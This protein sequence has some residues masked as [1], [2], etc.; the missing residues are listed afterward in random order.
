MRFSAYPIV[1]VVNILNKDCPICGVS[2]KASS[3]FCSKECKNKSQQNRI[4]YQC[5]SCKK[6]VW[7]TPAQLIKKKTEHI[8]CSQKCVG[9]FKSLKSK[10]QQ[11]IRSCP[12]CNKEFSTTQYY[13]D[14]GKYTFCS[15]I[16]RGISQR[17]IVSV[18]CGWCGT[19]VLKTPSQIEKSV[20]G[21]V[22]CSN[23]CVG[24]YNADKD[25]QNRITKNCVICGSPFPTKPSTEYTHITCS[26]ACQG[27][28]QSET[29]VG[30][31]ANNYQGGGGV[32]NCM[33][34]GEPFD[35]SK[36][37]YENNLSKF[38]KK[39]CK[40]EYWVKNVLHNEEFAKAHHVGNVKARARYPKETKPEKMVRVWL[41]NNGFKKNVH[42]KQEQSFFRK[43]IADFWFPNT[44]VVIE[45]NG[46]YWHAN[47]QIY[48]DSEG[49][50]PLNDHQRLQMKKDENR[51]SDFAKHNFTVYTLWENDIY[52]DVDVLLSNLIK[53]S[54]IPFPQSLVD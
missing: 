30:M 33:N 47:P 19:P 5:A 25:A 3:T 7:K 32:V 2:I 45:V 9:M 20:S 12:I 34:C 8:F 50:L 48:G 1:N 37:A 27:K 46:D 29:L 22:F 54:N 16:C 23:I 18:P 53:N 17:T 41:E 44:R 38:C 40:N 43:Y 31:N 15:S 28:W 39:K 6:P 26:R 13:I 11:I 4:E 49:L 14:A 10:E 52:N 36:Y 51:R 42:F 24:K 35:V 21:K